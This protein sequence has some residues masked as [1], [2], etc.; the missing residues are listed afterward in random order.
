V[1]ISCYY[2]QEFE[3]VLA[4]N[5]EYNIVLECKLLALLCFWNLCSASITPH[6]SSP[7]HRTSKTANGL[8]S[9]TILYSSLTEPS[10]F[11]KYDNK[12]SIIRPLDIYFCGS[13][14]PYRDFEKA[15]LIVFR[16]FARASLCFRIKQGCFF[17]N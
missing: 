9:S 17:F 12:T 16:S 6:R 11:Y 4:I 10:L 5:F 2:I 3:R 7:G 13:R 15:V 14:L 8:H 1:W